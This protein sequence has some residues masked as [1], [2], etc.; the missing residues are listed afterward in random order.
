MPRRPK[1]LLD[2]DAVSPYCAEDNPSCHVKS[3]NLIL[4]FFRKDVEDYEW[5]EGEGWLDSLLSLRSDPM[6]GNHRSL[7]PGWLLAVQ[8]GVF[9]LEEEEEEII[10]LT[11]PRCFMCRL[12]C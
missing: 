3:D 2:P 10:E 7:Y 8:E 6:Q 4:Y 12:E 5:V 11:C 1:R 9:G